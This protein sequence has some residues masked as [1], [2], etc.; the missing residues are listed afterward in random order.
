MIDQFGFGY[1]LFHV[2]LTVPIILILTYLQSDLGVVRN[3]RRWLNF[4]ILILIAYVYTIPWDNFM[5]SLDIWWYG[6]VV[7]NRIWHAPVGEYLFFGIQTIIAGLYLYYIGFDPKP[8][9]SDLQLS[10]RIIGFSL[11][12]ITAIICLVT[13]LYGPINLRYAT[14]ILAWTL[15]VLAI[16]WLVGGNY[17]L[18]KWKL[19]LTATT[20]PTVYLW[21]IDGYA[22]ATG[23]WTIN[24]ETSLGISV[25]ALPVEEMIFFLSANLM[26]VFGMILYEWVL[27][28]WKQGDGVFIQNE[29]DEVCRLYY[30]FE[31]ET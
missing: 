13:A 12:M 2:L 18:R 30:L 20:P 28:V 6:D 17:I 24:P 22:I 10:N 16:Q 21:L 19:V 26:T 14:S 7:W 31:N 1:L 15:P 8:E 23:M 29:N 25:G 3:R 27:E 4:V 9:Q 11:I 5:I